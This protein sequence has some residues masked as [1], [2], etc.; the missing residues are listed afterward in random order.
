MR[1]EAY[2]NV[3]KCISCGLISN[4]LIFRGDTDMATTGLAAATLPGKNEV[5]VVSTTADEWNTYDRTAIAKR[6]NET[7]NREG[8]LMLTKKLFK[9][10]VSGKETYDPICPSC[11][12]QQAQTVRLTL[13]EFKTAN[14][15]IHEML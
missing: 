14:G 8:F 9:N 7:L 15:I 6:V 5:V 12:N 10:A 3:C 4:D 2:I 11:G 13:E 1:Y